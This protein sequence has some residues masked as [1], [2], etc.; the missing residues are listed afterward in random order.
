MIVLKAKERSPIIIHGNES[1]VQD[2]SKKAYRIL[3]KKIEGCRREVR[4]AI[5][6]L[7]VVTNMEIAEFLG[8]EINRVTG[9]VI[10]LRESR[11]V[12]YSGHRLCSVTGHKVMSWRIKNE[13]I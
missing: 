3:Q 13:S 5:I 1:T 11:T 9:R 2:S 8:W 6:T 10:E 7:G 12:V 4:D